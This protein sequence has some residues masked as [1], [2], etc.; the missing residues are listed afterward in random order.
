MIP[1]YRRAA[2][3]LV[4]G[5][6]LAAWALAGWTLVGLATPDE[7]RG[8]EDRPVELA[9]PEAQ[10]IEKLTRE[11]L[12]PVQ[13]TGFGVGNYTF[14]GRTDENT[15]QASKIA[16]SLFSELSEHLWFF[17]Q[18]TT[19]LEEPEATEQAGGEAAAAATRWPA[20]DGLLLPQAAVAS[21]GGEEEEVVTEIEIDNLILSFT[22]PGLPELSFSIGKFDSPLGFER[23]DE[24]LNLQPTTSLNFEFGRPIKLVGLV[25][26]WNATPKINVLAMVT[27]GWESQ[28]DPNH[29]KTVGARVGFL[30]T[31]RT[32]FGIG[33][34]FGPEGEQGET[35]DRYLLSVD[36]AFQPSRG[37]VLAGEANYGG[38]DDAAEDGT[39]ARWAGAT[40]TAFGRV[41]R[42]FGLTARAEVFDD[43][44]GGRTGEEQ[45]IESFSLSPAF[46]FGTGREGIFTNIEHTTLRIP[47]FQLRGEIRVD[48]SNV[49]SFETSDGLDN[50]DVRYIVQLVTVF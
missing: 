7:A 11:S 23:D 6:T 44:D 24:P 42:R 28:V 19:L 4:A 29:G 8:Q 38:D 16:V 41:G 17:G 31:K 21:S 2:L 12:F 40:L 36:Y 47:R 14:E 32:S 5:R 46:L 25:G 15:F 20:T 27:N 35:T 18:L 48:R 1:R 9:G 33:G 10:E 37:F 45:T 3:A 34:T 30:P 26:R 43:M 22:P 39:D 49:D 13:I 50:W